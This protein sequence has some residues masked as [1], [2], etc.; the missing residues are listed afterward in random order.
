MTLRVHAIGLSMA[1]PN[2][3]FLSLTLTDQLEAKG[4]RVDALAS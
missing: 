1:S 3:G 2:V 4:S